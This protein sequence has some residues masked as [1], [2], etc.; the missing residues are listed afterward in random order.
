VSRSAKPTP[1][2]LKHKQSGKARAVWTDLIGLRHFRMLP[3]Q[4]GSQESCQAFS[5]LQAELA[6]TS[7]PIS[8]GNN[9]SVNEVLLAFQLFSEGHYRRA[10]GTFTEEVGEF[11]RV[12]RYVR[13]LYGLTPAKD[14]GP[15]A[16]KAIRTIFVEAGWCRKFVNKRVERIKHIFKWAVSEELVEETTYR[17]LATVTGLQKGRAAHDNEPIEPVPDAVVDTTLQFLN[18]H[19]RGLV[20]LQR[21]VGCRPGEACSIRRCDIDMSGTTWLYRPPQHKGTH[22]DKPRTIA[23]GPKAQAL[24]KE[25]FTPNIDD[26]LFSPARALAEHNAARAAKRKTPRYPSHQLRNSKKR[27]VSPKKVPG[28]KYGKDSYGLAIDRACDKAFPPPAPLAAQ[29]GESDAKWWKR[30]TTEQR[31]QVQEW[32][33]TCRWSPNQLRHSHGTKVRKQFGLEAAQVVLGHAR[34]DVTQVYAERNTELAVKVA[35]EIG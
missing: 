10:D 22:R 12:N 9:V 7:K 25:Y 15:L 34:A 14:F 17:A 19:V 1:S 2:Y 30:L 26:Y 3:G 18:R 33:K 31:S 24:L 29:P 13:E 21:L 16:L 27:K 4:Y 23:I 28:A 35:S 32:Q 20:D 5:R 11:K 8:R 6:A